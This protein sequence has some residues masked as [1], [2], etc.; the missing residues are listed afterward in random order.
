METPTLV[1][2]EAEGFPDESEWTPG[3]SPLVPNGR[4]IT[5]VIASALRDAGFCVS[6]PKQHEYY[7]WCFEVAFPNAAGWCLLQYPGPWLL[8]VEES[9]PVL[10]RLFRPGSTRNLATT[11]AA[12]HRVL[13]QDKRFSSVQW[14]TKHAYDAGTERGCQSP[15]GPAPGSPSDK[16]S[17]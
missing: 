10:R 9:L 3:G 16:V 13:T 17:P 5:G 8:L 15:V 1:T 6:D 12:I 11:V 7:G 2:F 4:S 14:F